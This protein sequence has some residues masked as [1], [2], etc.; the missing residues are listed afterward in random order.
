MY[1]FDFTADVCKLN[2]LHT[3]KREKRTIKAPN[4]M[5]AYIEHRKHYRKRGMEVYVVHELEAFRL[6][7]GTIRVALTMDELW[8]L[9]REA[10]K[11]ANI[12]T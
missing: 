10:E 4:K 6:K 3:K 5:T 1:E 7:Y 2:E 9:E 8:E 11:M 12:T